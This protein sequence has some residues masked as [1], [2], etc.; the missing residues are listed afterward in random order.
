M[1]VHATCVA[2]G[3]RGLLIRGA[4]GSGKSALALELIALGAELVADDQVALARAGDA[5]RARAPARLAGLIE[6]RGIGI[7]RLPFRADVALSLVLDMDAAEPG[8][9]PPRREA[10]LIDVAIARILRPPSAGAGAILAALR[11]GPA[12]DPDAAD[13]THGSN[14]V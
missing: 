11:H 9:L 8:R 5:V 2:L 3:A 12:L 13:A 6:A 10:R 4:P 7:L 14:P 1:I